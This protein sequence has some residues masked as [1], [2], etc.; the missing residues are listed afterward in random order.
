MG[1]INEVRLININYNNGGIRINDEAFCMN[2]ENT[3][4]S[5]QNGGGKSVLVQ[6][7]TAPFVHKA[8]R[9][10]RDRSFEGY[11]TGTKPSFILIEWS[12]DGGAGKMMNGFMIRKRPDETGEGEEEKDPL[13]I[14]S[15]ISEYDRPCPSD[16]HNLPV[17]EKTRK[18]LILKSFGAC[19][20]LFEG[21]KKEKHTKFFM[22]DMGQNA[23]QRQY[24]EKLKEYKVD[25]REWENI[26]KKVNQKEGGLSDLF[27]DCRDERG[28]T[29]K[30]FLDAVEKKLDSDGSKMREFGRITGMHA[31]QCFENEDKIKRRDDIRLFREYVAPEEE[32]PERK[33]IRLLSEELFSKDGDISAQEDK[34]IIF[35]QKIKE[36]IRGA[37]SEIRK[38][39]EETAEADKK[40]EELKYEKHS[41]EIHRLLKEKAEMEGN[42][43]ITQMELEELEKELKEGERKVCFFEIKREYD[44][45]QEEYRQRE[46]I[47][48]ELDTILKAGEDLKPRREELGKLLNG[49][50]TKQKEELSAKMEEAQNAIAGVEKKIRE[51]QQQLKEIDEETGKGNREAGKLLSE[52][53]LFDREEEQYFRNYGGELGRNILG[54]YED[55]ALAEEEVRLTAERKA[56]EGRRKKAREAKEKAELTGKKLESNL[57]D[58]RL[59]RNDLGHELK[60][61]EEERKKLEQEL[62]LRESALSFVSLGKEMLFKKE[63]ILR[64]FDGQLEILDAKLRNLQESETE[65]RKELKALEGG[66]VAELPKTVTE[67]FSRM[68]VEPSFGMEWLSKNGRELSRNRELVRKNPFL[69]Y[70]LIL[71]NREF[72]RLKNEEA[73]FYTEIPL[74]VILREDLDKGEVK[75]A[76]RNGTIAEFDRIRFY[77]NFN[78]NLL[79]EKKLAELMNSLKRELGEFSEKVLVLKREKDEYLRRREEIRVQSVTEELFKETGERL[80]NTRESLLETEKEISALEAEREENIESREKLDQEIAEE[81]KAVEELSG[82][83]K[84]LER[85][86]EDYSRYLV[87]LEK[88]NNL[89]KS[90]KDLENRKT[91]TEETLTKCREELG[92]Q[93]I[94]YEQLG[95]GKKAA[96]EKLRLFAAYEISDGEAKLLKPAE[97]GSLEAEYAAITEQYSGEV[98]EKEREL[99][100]QEKRYKKAGD[101]LKSLE[102]RYGIKAEETG[103]VIFS[104]D[105]LERQRRNNSETAGKA[106]LKREQR[107]REDKAISVLNT[108]IEDRIHTMEAET[109]HREILPPENIVS[110][111]FDEEIGL[112]RME[113]EKL[114]REKNALAE[115]RQNYR[116]IEK[117]LPEYEGRNA[118]NPVLFEEDFSEMTD[119]ALDEFQ[120]LLIRDLKRFGEERQKKRNALTDRLNDLIM[121]RNFREDFYRKPLEAMLRTVDAPAEVLRHIDI[122]LRSY[123]DLMKKIE[124]DLSVIEEERLSIRNEFA[125]YLRDVHAELSGIDSN[126]TIPVR[127]RT[128]KML[129]VNLPDWQEN[130]EIY[131]IRIRDYVEKLVKSCMD[132]KRRNETT[133]EFIGSHVNI[134]ELYD[135]VVGIGNVQ[136]RL[137]KIERQREYP[138]SWAEVSKNSGGEGFLSSFVILSSLLHYI[139][140]DDNDLFADRREGKVLL[141]DNPFGITYSEH[142][143]KPMMELAKKN[144]TQLICLTGLGGDSIYGRF[145]NIYVLN[146]VTG[147]LKSGVQYLR[148]DHIRGSEP[149]EVV[150]SHL[151]VS[152]Q[153]TLF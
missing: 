89:E 26:I 3:L 19:R 32:N 98:K 8:Y 106:G 45:L 119:N 46:K 108:R 64:A 5:L 51:K 56:A 17:V 40:I 73:D 131:R 96:E 85:L 27:S 81:G 63:E 151:E 9:R 88:K 109:G 86:M 153:L 50:Y 97:L 7:L 138:I 82:Q 135:A 71:T 65:K 15:I 69:P 102:K 24:F 137:Y 105:A 94:R 37:E 83:L 67:G 126:S 132:L 6:M 118:K 44:E 14:L 149:E 13:E 18:E 28:L 127:D 150:P 115:R 57:N 54:R 52:L 111:N 12:L 49:H 58:R 99:T 143:L 60:R 142:L 146:L 75:V 130:E 87:N 101:K 140:K 112:L 53:A 55:G 42:L 16:I 103:E 78:E 139:R 1:V 11:F 134:R 66:R 84:S 141:M 147:G 117:S 21:F 39:E 129:S 152:E 91:M 31:A 133:E 128:I 76:G 35:L 59:K 43:L 120:K 68:G 144:H 113:R 74:P 80:E 48:A 23:Q 72:E 79:D 2:G 110:R 148:P 10:T 90:L 100:D 36:L 93:R 114:E 123:E 29:E 30:W 22:Y 124:V 4:L 95:Q 136:I 62:S 77:V 61:I 41:Q 25:F 121:L 125:D 92:E 33:S 70:A 38:R 122:T 20:Q 116:S 104:E 47:R 145:D 34:L 107:H